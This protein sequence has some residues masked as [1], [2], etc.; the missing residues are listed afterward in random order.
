LKKGIL[1]V[2]HLGGIQKGLEITKLYSSSD[3]HLERSYP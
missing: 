2:R 3:P 1:G